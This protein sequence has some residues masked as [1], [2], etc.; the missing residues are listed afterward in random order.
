[1]FEITPSALQE[2]KRQQSYRGQLDFN[3]RIE[4]KEGGCSGLYYSLELTSERLA[5]D[6]ELQMSEIIFLLA[7]KSRTY[8]ENLKLDYVEDLMGGTFRFD[9]PSANM[10]C[11]CGLSFA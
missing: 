8:W 4:V 2:I 11:R 1:M 10:T 9:N 6:V 7:S 5:E 3:C